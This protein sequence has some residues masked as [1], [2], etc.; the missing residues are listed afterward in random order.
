MIRWRQFGTEVHFE[1]ECGRFTII[2]SLKGDIIA[3]YYSDPSEYRPTQESRPQA[4]IA[5]A[6]DWCES[7][8]PVFTL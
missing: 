8:I 5:D 1:S 7:R 3:R 2:R 4:S 6:K